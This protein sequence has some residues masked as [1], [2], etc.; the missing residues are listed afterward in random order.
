M[1]KFTHQ[2]YTDIAK[3]GNLLQQGTGSSVSTTL[4]NRAEEQEEK[5]PLTTDH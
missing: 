1:I 2:I 5:T 3:Y 4:N